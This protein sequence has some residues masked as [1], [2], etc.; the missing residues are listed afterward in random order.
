[1]ASPRGNAKHSVA[2]QLNQEPYRFSFVQAIRLIERI[3]G[4]LDSANQPIGGDSPPS[5]EAVKILGDAALGFPGAE[6][7]ELQGFANGNQLPGAERPELTAAFMG[8]YG[9]SGVLPHFDTQRI[10]DAG[11]RKN[12]EKDLLDLFN[13]RILSYFYRAAIKYR[14]QFAYEAFLSRK[15]SD[16]NLLTTILLSVGGMAT[17]GLQGRLEFPDEITIEFCQ[18]FGQ[19]TK[20]A[21]SLSRM[22]HSFLGHQVQIQ[23]F[24][25]QWLIL[26][27]GSKSYMP[28]RQTPLGQNCRLGES[29]IVGD[30]VWDVQSRF[31]VRLGPLNRSD[32]DA[33]L[34]GSVGLTQAA[35]LI[36]LYVGLALDFDI[37]L[38]L[39]ASD[40]PE[41]VLDGSSSRLG[42]NCW[43]ISR[44][45]ETNRQDAI[46]V[47]FG[48]PTR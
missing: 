24:Q 29:F 40:V 38:E 48:Q 1:M 23:Q 42:M 19:R 31:R 17:P 12:P 30:R 4:T 34:P 36:R 18:Y 28:T 35:Q 25:G 13:H 22:L 10:I 3:R 5:E 26:S 32:F 45:P 33:L 9:S 16:S 6:V 11:S 8:I 37:Q 46:F 44:Q 41:L 47:I 14:A 2:Q 39:L 7:V 15:N 27:D 21:I 20:N 43:L